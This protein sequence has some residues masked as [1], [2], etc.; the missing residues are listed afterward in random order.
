MTIILIYVVAVLVSIV[1][2]RQ[3]RRH[4]F[5][6]EMEYCRLQ[7][8]M[9]LIKPKLPRLESW[10][11]IAIGALLLL[12]GTLFVAL[13]FTVLLNPKLKSMDLPVQEQTYQAAG[14]IAGGLALIILGVKSLKLNTAYERLFRSDQ[15]EASIG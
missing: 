8:P 4:R 15:V 7:L 6:I 1:L 11:N 3:E 2:E 14:F 9:P 5:N 10:L 12:L 13:T